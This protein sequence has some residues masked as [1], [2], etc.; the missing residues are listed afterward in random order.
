[1]S[2]ERECH[3]MFC[4]K[5]GDPLQVRGETLICVRGDMPLSRRALIELHPHLRSNGDTTL[6]GEQSAEP[7]CAHTEV[8]LWSPLA[9]GVYGLLLGY[10][11]ALLLAVRN[12]QA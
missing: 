4:P 8:Q 10:P 7:P 3:S 2:A 12:W 5:C 11:S 9:V 6:A 1:M